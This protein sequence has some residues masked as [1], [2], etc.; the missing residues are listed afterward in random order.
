MIAGGIQ[1]GI[2]DEATSP[3]RINLPLPV[4]FPHVTTRRTTLRFVSGRLKFNGNVPLFHQAFHFA[5]NV[6][7]SP[8]LHVPWG[9]TAIIDVLHSFKPQLFDV[10]KVKLVDSPVDKVSSVGLCSLKGF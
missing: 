8:G 2:A 4:R 10:P 3:T 6:R 7:I 1:I 9:A 5:L